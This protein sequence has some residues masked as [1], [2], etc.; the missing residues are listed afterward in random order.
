MLLKVACTDNRYIQL[1]LHNPILFY[2][3]FVYIH[4]PISFYIFFDWY[5]YSYILEVNKRKK[6]EKIK[7]VVIAA[8][9]VAV[10]ATVGTAAVPMPVQAAELSGKMKIAG[11]T[12]VL[13][14]NQ[15]CA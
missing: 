9:V 10:I 7:A 3:C 5:I 1:R 12:T 13:P 4:Y 6:M 14:I 11:S 2:I 15:E 8:I